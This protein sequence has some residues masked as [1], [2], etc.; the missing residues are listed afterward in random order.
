MCFTWPVA[1]A[2]LASCSRL[3]LDSGL[4]FADD[5]FAAGDVSMLALTNW[6]DTLGG[7]VDFVSSLLLA[8]CIR[9]D[10]RGGWVG[11]AD[12]FTRTDGAGLMDNSDACGFL[13][14]QV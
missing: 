12:L 10:S 1:R 6:H 4:D 5:L 3:A 8:L 13:I 11:V 7:R 9:L 2:E 14:G